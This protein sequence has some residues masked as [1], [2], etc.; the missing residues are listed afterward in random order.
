MPHFQAWR[1]VADVLEGPSQPTR[2]TTVFP[3]DKKYWTTKH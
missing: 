3:A 1:E 2:C